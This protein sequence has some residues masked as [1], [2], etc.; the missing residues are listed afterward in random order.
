MGGV[1]RGTP[2]APPPRGLRPHLSAVVLP[3]SL[4]LDERARCP[5]H[6]R[7]AQVHVFDRL[8]LGQGPFLRQQHTGLTF[9]LTPLKSRQVYV[10]EV[11]SRDF[12][13]QSFA[14]E[15]IN[16]ITKLLGSKRKYPLV[17][18]SKQLKAAS[19]ES[20]NHQ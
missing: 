8:V 6:H 9:D 16:W 11:I 7:Q 17:N 10:L 18:T 13:H 1:K 15:I 4:E 20:H 3:T 12:K 2:G 14:T 5:V 19:K